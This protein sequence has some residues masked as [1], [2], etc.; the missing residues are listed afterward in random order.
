MSDKG[1]GNMG[2]IQ[3]QRN[4]GDS[5]PYQEPVS[6]HEDDDLDPE[7]K[8]KVR[9]KSGTGTQKTDFYAD[10]GADKFYFVGGNTKLIDCFI[11]PVEVLKEVV[12]YARMFGSVPKM[13]KGKKVAG[14]AT[15]PGGVGN[16]RGIGMKSGFAS[17]PPPFDEEFLQ[18]NEEEDDDEQD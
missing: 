4:A 9:K 12:S 15:F 8:K 11:N 3:K 10:L 6:H 7:I 17:A 5:Y 14:G 1:Y 18:R 13:Y 2:K 16:F